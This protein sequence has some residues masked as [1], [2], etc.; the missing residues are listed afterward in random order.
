MAARRSAG[1]LLYRPTPAGA[2][3][4]VAHMGGP[5]WA[6]RDAAAWTV[7]KG[8]YVDPEPALDAA[9]REFEEELGIA[10]PDVELVD[11]GSLRMSSG[12]VV[13]VWAGECDLDVGA[14]APGTFEMEWPRGSGRVAEFPEVDRV[15]WLD[16]SA[17]RDRLVAGQVVFLDRLGDLLATG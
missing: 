17:A 15:A 7:P 8:E 16:L 5:L 4:L 1:I 12:K 13:Q 3:V 10:V 2:D 14:F 6:G 11:L 9:R